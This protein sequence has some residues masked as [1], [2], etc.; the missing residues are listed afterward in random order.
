MIQYTW[1]SYEKLYGRRDKKVEMD[2]SRIGY[3]MMEAVQ[4]MYI[5]QQ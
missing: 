2:E 4:E 5:R 1:K 3:M